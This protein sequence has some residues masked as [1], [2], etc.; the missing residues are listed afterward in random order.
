M[1]SLSALCSSKKVRAIVAYGTTQPIPED[2]QDSNPWT[3]TITYQRRRMTV[4]FFTGSAISKE[5]TAADV[6]SCLLSDASCHDNA[7]SFED[8]ASDLGYDSDSRKAERIYKACGSI[9]KRLHRLLGDDFEEF[10][11]AEH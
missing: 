2:F 1:S 7:R 8:F 6:L 11:Q 5:P 10:A 9:S 3:V 4:P